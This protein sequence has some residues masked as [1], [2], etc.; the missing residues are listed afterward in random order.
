MDRIRM[1]ALES[2][3]MSADEAALHIKDGMTIATSGFTP[4]GY[5]KAVPKAL[6]AR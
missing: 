4:S 3:V 6:A 5:P 2:K 1:K